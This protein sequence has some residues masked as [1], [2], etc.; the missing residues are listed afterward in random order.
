M[1]KFIHL[2]L[3]CDSP[4]ILCGNLTRLQFYLVISGVKLARF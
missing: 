3:L 2:F 1:G 4:I